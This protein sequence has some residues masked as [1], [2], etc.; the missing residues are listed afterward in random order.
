MNPENTRIGFVGIGVMGKSMC[1]N[2]MR[3][4]YKA[5]IVDSMGPLH[6]STIDPLKNAMNWQQ[7]VLLL[8]RRPKRWQSIRILCFLLLGKLIV[9]QSTLVSLQTSEK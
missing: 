5:T 9:L 3:H 4:G 6:S 1:R 8:Q 2:L 7:K